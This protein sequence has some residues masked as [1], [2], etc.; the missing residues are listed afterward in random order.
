MLSAFIHHGKFLRNPIVIEMFVVFLFLPF[1]YTIPNVRSFLHGVLSDYPLLL[2]LL[3]LLFLFF[4]VLVFFYV[5]NR[6]SYQIRDYFSKKNLIENAYYLKIIFFRFL[7][8]VVSTS[9]FVYFVFPERFFY[10]WK[11]FSQYSLIILLVSIFYPILSVIPQEFI[12]R[13][14]FLH[15][16]SPLFSSQKE[17][18]WVNSLLFMFIHIIYENFVALLFTFLGNFLFMKT[19]LLTRSFWLVVLEHSLYGLWLFY[20]GLGRFFYHLRV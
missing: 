3:P 7:L 8:I 19:F 20:L 9:I 1:L 16:Y 11:D 18:I 5:I 2:K 12:F 6:N 15:R 10:F 14:Y 17:L 13:I 4:L